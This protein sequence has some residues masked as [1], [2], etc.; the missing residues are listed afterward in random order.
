MKRRQF[1]TTLIMGFVMLIATDVKAQNDA[2]FTYQSTNTRNQSS[3][4][5]GY[6]EIATISGGT[7]IE[8]YTNETPLTGG[9]LALTASG[10]VYL[11]GKRRKETE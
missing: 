10:L 8:S 2:F 5:I 3:D 7:G 4:V 9:L 11:I 1:L 6:G